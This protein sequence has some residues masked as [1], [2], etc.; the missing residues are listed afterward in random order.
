MDALLPEILKSLH[1]NPNL[2][3][4]APPG[5][6]KTSRVPPALLEIVKGEIIVLEPRRIAA[7]MAALRVAAELG[8][9]IGD[10][11]GY[12]VRFEEVGGRKTRLRY[13]TEGILTRRLVSES[14]LVGVDAVI[15]DEFHERHLDGDFALSLLKRL[16]RQRPELKIVVMSATLDAAPVALYLGDCP[17]IRSEGRLF[18]VSIRHLPYSSESL[19]AQ[20]RNAV[21]LLLSTG[22]K[23][24]TL[25]FLPGTAEIRQAMR[26]CDSLA[27]Q[28]GI[29]MLPLH[30]SL[31]TEEQDR[32]LMPANQP[33]LIFC[34][35]IAETSVTV[36]GV[37]AVID[38]GLARVSSYSPWTGLP[39]LRVQRISKASAKQRA[40][41]AGRTGPGRVIRLYPEEDYAL[42][43]E[44]D[45]PE[46]L[47][48]DLSKLCLSLR[49]MGEAG[50]DAFE[51][52]DA[53][54]KSAVEGA[55]MLLDRLGAKGTMASRLERYPLHPR[56]ARILEEASIRGASEEGCKIAALLE[57]GLRAETN[58]V[59]EAMDAVPHD[60]QFRRH[61]QQ[62]RRIARRSVQRHD[63]DDESVLISILSGFPDRVARRRAGK[64]LQLSNGTTAEI[65]GSVPAYEF[66][67]VLDV[68]D[69][70]DKS[71]PIARMMARIEPEWLI[72]L[73]PEDV[74]E[75]ENLEWNRISERVELVSAFVYDELVLQETRGVASGASAT[76]LLHRKAMESGLDRF[77][78]RKSVERLLA[79]INFAALAQ[80][81][82]SEAFRQ[83]C[84]GLSS[85]AE[86]EKAGQGFLSQLE[87]SADQRILR[88]RAPESIRLASGRQSKVHYENGKDPWVA[89]RLQDFFGMR[90]TPRIGVNRTP[91]VMHLLAPN[92]RAVQTTT[93]L[94]GFWQRLYPEVRRTLMRRY[95]KHSWPERP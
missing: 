55:Q 71:V 91:I 19:A 11:V 67:V 86:L 42:R 40:G 87:Q 81:D 47:N 93:D 18:E 38:S 85:F 6:G 23:G 10:T 4:E 2:V 41:R 12:Q 60:F 56:L 51:W 68:E 3:L 24:H 77:V 43:P 83:L 32:A 61:L 44:Q 80:P 62:L 14:D 94:S 88:E 37:T 69:R 30:G 74:R 15:L 63:V 92:H 1:R 84:T 48:A 22:N 34:T 79:R 59:L 16:Q 21:A 49:A 64:Q 33:K 72:D 54:P 9:G 20:I 8:E 45:V 35:N 29:L 13:V 82:V 39:T 90:E 28:N 52:I 73:F 50:P 26:E 36:E 31:S 58:D 76:E 7:R 89:S 95:P 75:R 27:S 5:A 65:H 46:I 57:V 70:K 66:M 53:P 25:I 78:D 17:V